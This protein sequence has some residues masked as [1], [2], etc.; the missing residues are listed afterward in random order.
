MK[1]VKLNAEKIHKIL[2]LQ[3]RPF[4]DVLLTTPI[5]PVI[6]K[7]FPNSE[8][9]FLVFEPYNTI[10]ENQPF[11]DKLLVRRKKDSLLKVIYTIRKNRYD[12]V[13]DYIGSNTSAFLSFLSGA[14]WRVGYRKKKLRMLAYNIKAIHG[15]KRY[16]AWMKF[17]L[18][19]SIGIQEENYSFPI[20]IAPD[21]LEFVHN[22]LN[23]KKVR[24]K[25]KILISPNS[26][27]DYKKWKPEYFAQVANELAKDSSNAVFI[28]EGPGEEEYVNYVF[29]FIT[30]KIQRLSGL[31]IP[32]LLAFIKKMDLFI[33]NCGGPK[34]MAVAV[35]TPSITIFGPTDPV[36]WHPHELSHHIA[37]INEKKRS[38]DNSFG[39]TPDQVVQ[40]AN[41]LLKKSK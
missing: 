35:G 23:K 25:R 19:K 32:N 15:E 41:I 16:S 24:G 21:A 27:R 3:F 7:Y 31:T 4:G 18:L 2:I 39:I 17:D 36:V 1:N 5:L 13:L 6:K 40:H 33:G 12:L 28:L 20:Q 26:P 38:S 10:L 30:E 9:H 22:Y 14:P 29:Q 34:H 11:I 8:I 37:L